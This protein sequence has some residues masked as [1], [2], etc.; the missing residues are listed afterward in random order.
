M[1]SIRRL[2]ATA[3]AATAVATFGLGLSP[4]TA[5]TGT[6]ASSQQSVGTQATT[7]DR[8]GVQAAKWHVATYPSI[9]L[10]E[11]HGVAGVALGHYSWYS[12]ETS[13]FILWELW[14]HS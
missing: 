5:S 7:S 10:C 1:T 11:A 2:G 9:F 3:A 14:G 12:C 6:A 8:S 13:N 4:A